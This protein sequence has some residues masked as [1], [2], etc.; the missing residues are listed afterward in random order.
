MKNGVKIISCFKMYLYFM[1]LYMQKTF[2]FQDITAIIQFIHIHFINN[3]WL[4]KL[5]VHSFIVFL[6]SVRLLFSQNIIVKAFTIH[7]LTDAISS[8]RYT[9]ANNRYEDYHFNTPLR[10]LIILKIIRISIPII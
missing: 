2:H 9:R 3:V 8:F 6:A 1:S 4:L 7:S 5:C 10:I